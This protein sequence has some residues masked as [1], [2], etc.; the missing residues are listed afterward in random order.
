MATGSSTS[1]LSHFTGISDQQQ[2]LAIPVG[3]VPDQFHLVISYFP[4]V[5][6]SQAAT[7]SS[8]R[9]S[10]C[11]LPVHT[12]KC[13]SDQVTCSNGVC[14]PPEA[15][16]DLNDDCGNNWDEVNCYEEL[17]EHLCTFEQDASCFWLYFGFSVF[18]ASDLADQGYIYRDHTLNMAE[19][20]YLYLMPEEIEALLQGQKMD[21]SENCEVRNMDRSKNVLV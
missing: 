3:R 21:P 2:R 18:S 12:F 8:I 9:T 6:E 5:S 11:G 17:E 10:L 16:C 20:K 19:G 14:I 15:V 1:I 4:G 7:I 13:L